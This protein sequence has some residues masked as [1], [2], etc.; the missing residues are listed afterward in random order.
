VTSGSIAAT[1]PSALDPRLAAVMS[2]AQP[3]VGSVMTAVTVVP[4]RVTIAPDAQ[5]VMTA[6]TVVPHRVMSVAQP[7]VGSVTTAATVVQAPVPVR[8]DDPRARVVTLTL[9][10]E[11]PAPAP[12]AQLTAPTGGP[13]QSRVAPSG[14][15]VRTTATLAPSTVMRALR[16]RLIVMTAPRVRLI[17]T[18]A[19]LVMRAR[20]VMTAPHDHSTAMRALRAR[21]IVM[22]VPRV[23]LIV[24]RPLRAPLIVM[25]AQ[26]GRSIGQIARI[27]Q[28]DQ[29]APRERSTAMAVMGA[30]TA[31]SDPCVGSRASI[32]AVTRK[33]GR[34]TTLCSIALRPMLCRP[35]MLR[36]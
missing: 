7:L 4:L 24:T 31:M 13:K 16:A 27:A 21:L 20:P 8:A 33:L 2:V 15:R 22:T 23:R 1:P 10:M 26:P 5:P 32:R 28:S 25:R 18:V 6:G 3:L 19:R 29:I 30:L 35:P 9:A 36:V 14:P 11:L 12:A 34:L 17:V